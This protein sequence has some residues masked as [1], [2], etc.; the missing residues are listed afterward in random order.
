MNESHDRRVAFIAGA[1][2]Y[3]GS[4][5]VEVL[6]ERGW[7]VHAHVRPDSS[8]LPK[9]REKFEALGAVVDTTPWALETM[10]QTIARIQPTHLFGMLG[11]TRARA[12]V[13]SGAIEDTYDAVDYGLSSMLLR[14]MEAAEVEG[15]YI[16]LSSLGVKPGTSNP[17]LRARA[18]M[19]AE[20]RDS[21]VEW[22]VVRPAL[23]TGDD[24]PEN[25]LSEKISRPLVGGALALLGVFS[26]EKKRAFM[27]RD[28]RLL[29]EGCADAAEKAPSGSELD[30]AGLDAL[31]S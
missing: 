21:A 12:K 10:T 16:Y 28:G 22:V 15:K 7:E 5:L 25:R 2:G 8:A 13:G 26:E 9:W 29:A 6:R 30:G 27:T 3:T 24:R 31:R 20:L 4:H 19:E 23:I 17:Y 1:T 18:K 11:T 14:A